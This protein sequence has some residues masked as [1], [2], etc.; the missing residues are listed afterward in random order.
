MAER[1]IRLAPSLLSADFSDLTSAIRKSEAGGADALHLDVMDGHFVPNISFGPALVRAVRRRTRLPLDVHLMIEHP[2]RFAP[3]FVDAGGDTL[4]FHVESADRPEDV[5]AEIQRLK[6][7][8]GVALRPGTPFEMVEPFL[9]RLDQVLV[10]S[11]HPGFSGQRFLPEVLPK[12]REARSHLGDM[13]PHA[14][15]SIDG[16]ITVETARPAAEAGATFFVCGNSVFSG[17]E[18]DANLH[19]LRA[20]ATGA[21][22]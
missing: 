12:L 9:G 22:G 5:I 16:G 3:A 17:G 14:D 11:V 13:R 1:G 20:V 10:M 18:V 19:A 4:V 6:T 7:R 2:L 8:V 21:T 15:I